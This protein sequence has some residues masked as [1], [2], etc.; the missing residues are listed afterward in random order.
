MSSENHRLQALLVNENRNTCGYTDRNNTLNLRSAGWHTRRM[1]VIWRLV[2]VLSASAVRAAHPTADSPSCAAPRRI[3]I[4]L[5]LNWCNT[6]RLFETIGGGVDQHGSRINLDEY[7]VYGLE[8]SP[9]IWPFAERYFRFLNGERQ[10]PELC[11][12]KVTGMG[13]PKYGMGG[14]G[15]AAW[16]GP[17]GCCGRRRDCGS[18][19][20]N[21]L[22]RCLMRE[23]NPFITATLQPDPRLNDTALVKARLANAK[24]RARAGGQA[25]RPPRFTFVPAA[26]GTS[27]DGERWLDF[28]QVQPPAF[29]RLLTPS[30]LKR[31]IDFYQDVVNLLTGGGM[32]EEFRTSQVKFRVPKVDVPG[33]IASSFSERDHIVLKVDIE[34]AEHHVLP[35]MIRRGLMPLIDV[36]SYE[37]HLM[38]NGTEDPRKRQTGTWIFSANAFIGHLRTLGHVMWVVAPTRLD[39]CLSPMHSES[40]WFTSVR[41]L[42]ETDS[43][44]RAQTGTRLVA[45]PGVSDIAAI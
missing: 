16:Y 8:A 37:C 32:I 20:I 15:L 7:E 10:E 31:W 24:C 29:S 5:G 12:P 34:G 25:S 45:S 41:S 42:A 1:L 39:H 11:L 33:W 21:S 6:A 14:G 35:E 9:L 22:T 13:D 23:L 3:Y 26:A 30:H 19:S 44:G 40:T 27:S 18:R 38:L 4:D 2:A 28:Y 43:P 17:Y 36:L